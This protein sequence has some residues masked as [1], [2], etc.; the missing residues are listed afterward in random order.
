MSHHRTPARCP[1]PGELTDRR[2]LVT[3]ASSG[4]G[5]H[6]AAG[7]AAAGAHVLMPV[8]SRERGQQAIAGVVDRAPDVTAPAAGTRASDLAAHLELRD[9]DL[10]RLDTVRAL[11]AELRAEG[12]R[13]DVLVLNAGIA[14]P[15]RHP[16]RT[17]DGHDLHMQTNFLAQALL[18]RELAPLLREGRGRIVV[19]SSLAADM[20]TIPW[21]DLDRTR[22]AGSVRAAVGVYGTSKLTL[23]LFIMALA[24]HTARVGG[25]IDVQFAQPG[26]SLATSIAPSIRHLVPP[27]LLHPIETHLGNPPELA[28]RPALAAV[29]DG[30]PTAMHELSGPGGLGGSSVVA[31]PPGRKRTDRVAAER[32]WTLVARYA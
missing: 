3:G 24:D 17:A 28:A 30:P 32:L 14:N 25:G 29:V 9:L 12:D 26:A 6:I 31:R 1:G 20:A 22:H 8:R 18:A 19:Q 13:L 16:E 2:A 7:L 15:G 21:D 23:D 11:G 4:I 10:A 27:P 5:V